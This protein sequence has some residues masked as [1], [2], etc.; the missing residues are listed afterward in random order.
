MLPVKAAAFVEAA[1]PA[2]TIVGSTS[3]DKRPPDESSDLSPGRC[4]AGIFL[5]NPPLEI[6]HRVTTGE[7]F[8][9]RR[10]LVEDCVHYRRHRLRR[11]PYRDA[12]PPAW[13]ARQGTGP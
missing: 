5:H 8:G 6:S 4:D 12:L 13:L 1:F 3:S 11:Q 9:D 7:T 2:I 10:L